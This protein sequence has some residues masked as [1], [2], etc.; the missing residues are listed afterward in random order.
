MPPAE[1]HRRPLVVT[2]RNA[3]D[4]KRHEIRF[5]EPP[6]AVVPRTGI[7]GVILVD[8]VHAIVE[9][10][11]CIQA[12]RIV[13]RIARHRHKFRVQRQVDP[14]AHIGQTDSDAYLGCGGTHPAQQ[15]HC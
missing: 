11:I 6:G 3:Q 9:E 15:Q 10:I 7:P 12:R 1:V 5:N 8:P 13:D 2:H 4:V 14:D